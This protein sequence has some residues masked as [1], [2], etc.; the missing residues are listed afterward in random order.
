[1]HAQRMFPGRRSQAAGFTVLEM[2]FASSLVLVVMGVA[3]QAIHRETQAL[4][5]ATAL[6]DAEAGLQETLARLEGSLRFSRGYTPNAWSQS[7]L[8]PADTILSVDS[9]EA[10]PNDG[11]LV[12]NPGQANEERMQYTGLTPDAELRGLQRGM[13][14]TPGSAHGTGSQVLWA[15][16]ALPIADQVAPPPSQFDGQSAE[17]GG[18]L[19]FRGP[20]CGFSY[21]AP[22]DPT[23]GT[24]YLVGTDVQWGAVVDGTPLVGGGAAVYFAPRDTAVEATL[25]IDLNQDGDQD[26]AFDVGQLRLRCW[27]AANPAAGSTDVA[28]SSPMLIQEQ[29]NWGGDLDGDG[30][31]DPMFLWDE[32]R[33]RL[34]VRL[35]ALVSMDE[36]TVLR[37]AQTTLFLKNSPTE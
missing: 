19:F 37:Q 2:V 24:D 20:G 36:G 15:G 17:P 22:V 23:G 11:W 29:C 6:G 32:E 5:V 28:L 14:C 30:F 9:T 3:F 33:R 12:V 27:D 10:F 18:A 4:R 8:G 21:C 16:S 34:R 31:E 25:A 35:F 1:M 26:D 13:A 7:A